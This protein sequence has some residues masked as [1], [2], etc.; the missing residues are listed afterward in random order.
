MLKGSI[1]YGKGKVNYHLLQVQ[2]ARVH[3]IQIPLI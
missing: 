3:Q 2:E 1:K